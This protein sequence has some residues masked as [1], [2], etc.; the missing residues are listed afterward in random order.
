M[1]KG[2]VY[3]SEL[4]RG[5]LQTVS[6]MGTPQGGD[7][8]PAKARFTDLRVN[9]VYRAG[10]TALPPS[11]P[12]PP[13]PSPSPPPAAGA[14]AGQSG[15]WR[16]EYSVVASCS[17]REMQGIIRLEGCND[18]TTFYQECYV[19]WEVTMDRATRGP[20]KNNDRFQPSVLGVSGADIGNGGE[21]IGHTYIGLRL[22]RNGMECMHSGTNCSKR[23][24]A[25]L[26]AL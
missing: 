16:R 5:D 12:S 24:E 26:T 9:R 22:K 3:S 13:S 23:K 17:E 4:Y 25:K 11:L 19:A 14:G 1:V 10:T 15:R 8:T 21:L 6:C 20:R 2:T 7:R 18:F